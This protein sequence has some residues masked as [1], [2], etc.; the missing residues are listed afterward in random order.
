MVLTRHIVNIDSS[1]RDTTAYPTPAQYQISLPSRYRNVWE[2]RLV[3]IGIPE[4]TPSRRNVF[5]KI[6]TLNQL[7][8]T[9]NSGGVNFCFAKLPLFLQI[10]NNFYIDSLSVSIPPTILQNPIA[11][12]DKLNISFTDSRGNVISIAAGND[13]SM[14]IELTCGDYINNGG[15]STITQHGRI[16][17]GTR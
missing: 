11:S 12:M 8:S 10:S 6:D 3:N 14:Q 2:A 7:G 13:H 4:F 15:G 9:S 17:G 5:V 1:D 16:L